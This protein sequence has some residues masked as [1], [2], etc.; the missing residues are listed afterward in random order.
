MDEQFD[1]ALR[2]N[3]NR[4][5][6]R[7][8]TAKTRSRMLLTRALE[9][10]PVRREGLDRDLHDREPDR[11]DDQAP[12]DDL[13]PG[14]LDE[15]VEALAERGASPAGRGAEQ[16]RGAIGG[17]GRLARAWIRRLLRRVHREGGGGDEA[18]R[19]LGRVFEHRLAGS[20]DQA[21]PSP[22]GAGASET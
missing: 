15:A 21:I 7:I 13:R 2:S 10:G 5:R 19:L 16:A 3:A 1:V 14:E 9:D 6:S 20:A 18:R 11:G 12:D 4:A 22:P 17:R 8:S